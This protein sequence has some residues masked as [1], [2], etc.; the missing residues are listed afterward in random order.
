MLSYQFW[1]MTGLCCIRDRFLPAP[2]SPPD[3]VVFLLTF[4]LVLLWKREIIEIS[5]CHY[6][7]LLILFNCLKIIRTFTTSSSS[8][9]LLKSRL[10]DTLWARFLSS[11]SRSWWL[12][13]GHHIFLKMAMCLESSWFVKFLI[14]FGELLMGGEL[15]NSFL[16]LHP[17]KLLS[18]YLFKYIKF[19]SLD[20]QLVITKN[21]NNHNNANNN[22]ANL[23]PRVTWIWFK[24]YNNKNS[25]KCDFYKMLRFKASDNIAILRYFCSSWGSNWL[26]ANTTIK[27][28][29]YYLIGK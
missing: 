14:T 6:S 7:F 8:L 3:I 4:L 20:S 23:F 9:L 1:R 19:N 10:E 27:M 15:S 16:F 5:D 11:M 2:A 18:Y 29:I 22:N 21:D 25:W 28:N 12:C 24:K 26:S 17:Y 13:L